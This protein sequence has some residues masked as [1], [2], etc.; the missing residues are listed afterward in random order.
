MPD[1][2]EIRARAERHQQELDKNLRYFT[3]GDLAK[4]WGCSS[5]TVRA[6]AKTTLPYLNLGQGLMRELRRY[7]PEDVEAYEA[8][9]LE[10]AS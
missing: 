8:T 1:L 9:R 10:H 4:R 5:T 6:I 3:V 2:A 7:R